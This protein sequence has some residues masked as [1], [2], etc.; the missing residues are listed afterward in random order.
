MKD[1]TGYIIVAGIVLA[2]ILTQISVNRHIKEHGGKVETIF[3][4]KPKEIIKL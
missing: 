2:A 1:L 4:T 3:N